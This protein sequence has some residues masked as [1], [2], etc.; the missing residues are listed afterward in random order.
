MSVIDNS[1][2]FQFVLWPRI[3]DRNNLV[4]DSDNIFILFYLSTAELTKLHN[5]LSQKLV[6]SKRLTYVLTFKI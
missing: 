3:I 6:T 4:F 1:V 5:W 2:N